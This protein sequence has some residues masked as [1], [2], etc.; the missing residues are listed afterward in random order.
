MSSFKHNSRRTFIKKLGGTTALVAS[1]SLA[2]G[3]TAEAETRFLEL[4]KPVVA[5]DK[6]RLACIGTGIMGFNDINTALKVPGVELVAVCDLYDGRL[7]RAKE[8]Y[9]S[10]LATTRD[11]R[12]LL[13]RKD[14][15]AVI[16]ATTDHW[17]DRISI[18]A[19]EKG[20]A[21]YCEKPMVHHIEEGQKVIKTQKKTGN[22]FQV[23]SQRLSSIVHEKAKQL[24]QAGEIGE[25]NMVEATMD[26]HSALGAWQ[27][28]IP[29]DASK[30]TIDWQA[31]LGDAPKVPFDPVRFFRWRNYQDYG[32]GV[33]GDLFVHLLTGLHFITG[34]L[35]PTRIM[36]SGGLVYWKDGRD[37]PDVMI[38][39]L[40][41]PKT[42]QHPSFQMVM[43]VNFA[44]G[45]GGGSYTRLVGSEGE[46]RIGQNE[47][48]IKRDKMPE[49]PGY[50]GWDSFSTF[51]EATQKKFEE[52]YH[53]Q[54]PPGR[55]EMIG[56]KEMVYKAP[57]GYSEH[58]DHVTNFFDSMRTNKPVIEDASF[59]LRAAGPALATN[60]S[61]FEKKIVGWDPVKMKVVKAT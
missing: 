35:G 29:P 13:D 30:D 36:S 55:P 12:E 33:A 32:T 31:F 60:V 46:M 17:H 3:A 1:G 9:G 40:D 49:A 39:V 26:R 37:V 47:V 42:E 53:A 28:S 24:Y 45:S 23:G 7:T 11:Y 34:S 56:P 19:M 5:N 14:I 27:Y 16:V 48:T 2:L 10:Q 51:P 41:Y 6:I 59:G 8:L 52:Q 18:D 20:K 61:Y 21:V 58:L 50:G 22:V 4:S 38:S 57:E 44:D 43:R 25:L 54:Y 15:D